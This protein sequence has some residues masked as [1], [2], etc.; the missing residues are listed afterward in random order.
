M[1]ELSQVERQ[2]RRRRGVGPEGPDSPAAEVTEHVVAKKV[3]IGRSAVDESTGDRAVAASMAVLRDGFLEGPGAAAALVWVEPLAAIPA[4]VAAARARRL[5]VDLLPGVLA[6][7]P[8]PEGVGH[9]VE[10]G[11]PGVTQ[12]DRPDVPEPRCRSV[13][14]VGRRTGESPVQVRRDAQRFPS[15][16]FRFW[17]FSNGSPPPPPSPVKM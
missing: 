1:A 4:V 16:L 9:P 15:A 2:R 13:V 5:P 10:A 7:I 11:T 8:D 14:R 3:G 6:D 17:P 12:P